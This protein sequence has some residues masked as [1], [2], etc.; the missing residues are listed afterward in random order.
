MRDVCGLGLGLWAC[1]VLGG[2]LVVLLSCGC[3]ARVTGGVRVLAGWSWRGWASCRG[4]LN[5]FVK[6]EWEAMSEFF[7]DHVHEEYSYD[8]AVS[9]RFSTPTLDAELLVGDIFVINFNQRPF[10]K[11]LVPK[12]FLLEL[13]AYEN[14]QLEVCVCVC[15]CA[16][17][18]AL[19]FFPLIPCQRH[20]STS[21]ELFI[22][23]C[24]V[25][26]RHCIV[27]RWY[28]TTLPPKPP[29][30]SPTFVPC[31]RPSPMCWSATHLWRRNAW[32][33][34]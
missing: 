1:A 17:V 25:T 4:D 21:L 14:K 20:T 23:R 29:S 15:V 19:C 7:F 11:S 9:E 10:F 22:L 12:E 13:L 28:S 32:I 34:S 31:G 16:C 30:R 3:C 6:S 2:W 5:A 18:R 24:A 33:A 26:L 8:P 27:S